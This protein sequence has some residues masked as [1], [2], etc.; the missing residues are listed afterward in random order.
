MHQQQ[1][2]SIE[3]GI[4]KRKREIDHEYEKQRH[5]FL[6]N[7]DSELANMWITDY[8][9]RKIKTLYE[10]QFEEVAKHDKKRHEETM[11][12]QKKDLEQRISIL[13]DDLREIDYK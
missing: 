11:Q 3:E 4:L 13:N 1:L 12:I 7:F 10:K 8:Q 2:R 9:R 5:E 6:Q